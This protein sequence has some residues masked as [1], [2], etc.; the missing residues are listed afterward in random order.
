MNPEMVFLLVISYT[1]LTLIVLA[2]I[3]VMVYAKNIINGLRAEVTELKR[4]VVQTQTLFR[5][6]ITKLLE[7]VSGV[8]KK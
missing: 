5:N 4:E 8:V 6:Q 7:D 1:V 3:V 2:F